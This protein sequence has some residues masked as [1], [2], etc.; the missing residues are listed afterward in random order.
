VAATVTALADLLAQGR[1]TWPTILLVARRAAADPGTPHPGRLVR[2]VIPEDWWAAAAQQTPRPPWPPW[3]GDCDA[4]DYRWI[5][6][7]DGATKCPTCNPHA[8]PAGAR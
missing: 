1:R 2:G 5:E 8:A 4:D 6:T 3:C 7:P